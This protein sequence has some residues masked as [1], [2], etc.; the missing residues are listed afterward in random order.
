M[1]HQ[2]TE[3]RFINENIGLGVFA[4][5]DIPKG[6]IVWVQ[7]P[8]DY[9]LTPE[10]LKKLPEPLLQVVMKYSFRNKEGQYVLCWDTTRFVNHSFKPNTM[11]TPYDFD[12][13]IQDIPAGTEFRGDY[14]C[15]NIIEAFEPDAE[16]GS[17]RRVVQ[18]DDLLHY[19]K[20][21][22]KILSAVFPLIT[23]VEQPMRALINNEKWKKMCRIAEGQEKLASLLSCYYKQA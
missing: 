18:P 3:V 14:G 19:H 6:T 20:E 4:T 21:W 22:D 9:A 17:S 5:E 12:V 10:E 11:M 23:A 2:K 16:E 13:A 1:I 15:L 7:D 8:L